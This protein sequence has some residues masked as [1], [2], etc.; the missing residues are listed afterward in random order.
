MPVKSNEL[1]VKF[2][3][4]IVRDARDYTWLLFIHSIHLCGQLIKTLQL[5]RNESMNFF[6]Q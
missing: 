6:F 5:D 2:F 3:I 4:F 1:N